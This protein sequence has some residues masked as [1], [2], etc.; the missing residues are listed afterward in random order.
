MKQV[1]LY[2]DRAN[3]VV[4]QNPSAGANPVGGMNFIE[5][6]VL[7]INVHDELLNTAVPPIPLYIEQSLGVSALRASIVTAVN[8]PPTGGTFKLKV[9]SQSTSTLTWPT[10]S[11]ELAA[12]KA[13]CLA[14]LEALSNVG[15]GQIISVDP[16]N[17]PPNL[18]WYAWADLTRTDPI[19]VVSNELSPPIDG[20]QTGNLSDAGYTQV[21]SLIQFPVAMVATYTNPSTP[22]VTIAESVP[23]G[24]GRS[25]EQVITIPDEATGSFTLTYSGSSTNTFPVATVTAQQIA[26]ALNA[27]VPNG[28][29][30]PSFAVVNRATSGAT[31]FAIRFQGPLGSMAQSLLG[32]TMY[33][34]STQPYAAL[35][36]DLRNNVGIKSALNGGK[37]AAFTY[38]LV[39][40]EEEHYLIPLTVYASATGPY[41][42]ADIAAAGGIVST[43]QT[44]YVS[45]GTPTI[46]AA[47]GFVAQPGSAGNPINVTHTLAT[48]VPGIR[49]I[50][51]TVNQ[52]T[53]AAN[54]TRTAGVAPAG[55]IS[56]TELQ[57]QSYSW[58]STADNALQINLP[59]ITVDD[60]TSPLDYR[61]FDI[62]LTSPDA[63][64]SIFTPNVLWANCLQSLGG[65]DVGTA[66]TA[67]QN[68][69]SAFGGTLA[70]NAN[71]I[72]S[73]LIEPNQIDLSAL[74]TA[75]GASTAF[76]SAL[77]S[78]FQT[79]NSF[80]TTL[81]Q[82]MGATG[83]DANAALI[84]AIVA[85]LGQ[86]VAGA[87]PAETLAGAITN[88]IVLSPAFV[89]D[90]SS[91][92]EQF[93][94]GGVNL[95]P[96]LTPILESPIALTVPPILTQT[97]GTVTSPLYQALG[98]PIISGAANGG[99]ITGNLSDFAAAANTYYT[100][101]SGAPTF[102]RS[103]RN[104]RGHYFNTGDVITQSGGY[105]YKVT[106]VTV[107]ANT[108]Y[109]PTET[110]IELCSVTVAAE[111]FATGQQFTW[112]GTPSFCL[113][114]ASP[115]TARAL[116]IY[117]MG[118]FTSLASDDLSSL[119]WTQIGQQV[120]WLNQATQFRRFT[121][122]LQ[123]VTDADV[124][125]TLTLDSQPPIEFGCG[126]PF[127]GHTTSGSATVSV[128]VTAGLTVGQIVTGYG[129]VPGASITAITPGTSIVLSN[130]A[131][132]TS[133]TNHLLMIATQF[134]LRARLSQLSP[135]ATVS[136]P[137][138]ALVIAGNPVANYT[139]IPTS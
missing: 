83:T 67:L 111:L 35:T 71:Q 137:Q 75:L 25:E 132:G 131:T 8:A 108:L 17:T 27:L 122:L 94:A 78:L 82:Q 110:E 95:P 7:Q 39:L 18:L 126:L 81:A 103:V 120:L 139:A 21:I 10:S 118:V 99:A 72:T 105:W 2:L 64:V 135:D 50:Q 57:D 23:G 53:F 98:S 106:P 136:N 84:A 49:I 114:S 40:D 133:A 124:P 24:S 4:L 1:D 11:G 86:N 121:A 29:T 13:T 138:G 102:F 12:W 109:F 123:N 89:T 5:N 51:Y 101:G 41:T 15:A 88:A 60:P 3:G 70:I 14:A 90:I 87:T 47:T 100:V 59:F 115:L 112:Q 6:D 91:T 73:G 130:A 37:S 93:L 74:S 33:D 61:L 92:I 16:P 119:V 69:V 62:L 85:S 116:L 36:L 113:K 125:A 30:N 42:E 44:V 127:T 48:W 68:A 58:Q 129:V 22:P 65:E 80:A 52:T 128:A 76:A 54:P 32:V 34:Q 77:T 97:V 26:L 107:G 56:A 104:R 79:N 38:E 20:I 134:K 55:V 31:S 28:A 63:S 96:G 46:S 66:I 43:V 45:G 9:G 117:E 19:S